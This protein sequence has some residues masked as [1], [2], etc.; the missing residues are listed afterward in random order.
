MDMMSSLNEKEGVSVVFASHDE[1]VLNSVKRVIKLND[2][3]IVES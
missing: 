1:L 3:E 2:G